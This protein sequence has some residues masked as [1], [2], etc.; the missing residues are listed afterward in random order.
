ML[1]ISTVKKTTDTDH[2]Q[3]LQTASQKQHDNYVQ[4]SYFLF[5]KVILSSWQA[6]LM[7][8]GLYW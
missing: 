1:H 7:G 3:V 2:D 5:F 4:Y 6:A 8:L